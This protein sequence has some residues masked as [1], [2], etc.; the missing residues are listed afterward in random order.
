[1]RSAAEAHAWLMDKS[2]RVVVGEVTKSLQRVTNMC[3]TSVA[4][5]CT[6]KGEMALEH[7]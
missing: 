1:M 2:T 3:L 7:T 6:P 4:V 5:R